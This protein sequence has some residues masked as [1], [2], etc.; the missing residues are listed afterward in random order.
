MT[1]EMGQKAMYVLWNMQ[2]QD[3]EGGVVLPLALR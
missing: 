3:R 2:A 1:T